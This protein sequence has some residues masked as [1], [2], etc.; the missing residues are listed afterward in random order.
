MT[1][2]RLH[3]REQKKMILLGGGNRLKERLLEIIDAQNLP[4]FLGGDCECPGRC[5]SGP[6]GTGIEPSR[7]Q[8]I[9]KEDLDNYNAKISSP[10]SFK[11]WQD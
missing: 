7:G 9:M 3:F 4:S 10:S 11:F 6:L 2:T 8:E 5:I 1:L